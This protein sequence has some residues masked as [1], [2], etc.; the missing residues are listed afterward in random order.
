MLLLANVIDPVMGDKIRAFV[1]Q[2]LAAP[3]AEKLGSAQAQERAAML[4]AV[5]FGVALIRKNFQ[6]QGLADK[7][8]EAL[9]AQ[10]TALARAA[11]EFEP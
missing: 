9:R 2:G 10:I 5:L 7:S 4:L 3:L 6:I 1:Q 8:P 11:L